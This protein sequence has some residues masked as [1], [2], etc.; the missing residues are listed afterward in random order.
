M[1]FLLCILEF[2]WCSNKGAAESEGEDEIKWGFELF[3]LKTS[4]DGRQN[5]AEFEILCRSLFEQELNGEK[6]FRDNLV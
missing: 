5:Q 2:I 4:L 1:C 6:I 3:E